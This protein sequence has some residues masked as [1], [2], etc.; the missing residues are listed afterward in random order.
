VSPILLKAAFLALA[1]PWRP[2]AISGY[3]SAE[4]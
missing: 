4:I 3:L 1:R 2:K